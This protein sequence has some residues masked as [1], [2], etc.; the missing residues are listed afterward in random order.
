MDAR[1]SGGGAEEIFGCNEKVGVPEFLTG[2]S[3]GGLGIARTPE[4]TSPIRRPPLDTCGRA[5]RTPQPGSPA[6]CCVAGRSGHFLGKVQISH[7]LGSNGHKFHFASS[8][9]STKPK[10]RCLGKRSPPRRHPQTPA[11]DIIRTILA[12]RSQSQT[13]THY[14]MTTIDFGSSGQRLDVTLED[15]AAMALLYG[16]ERPGPHA[17]TKPTSQRANLSDFFN[18][19]GVNAFSKFKDKFRRETLLPPEEQKAKQEQKVSGSQNC[20][21]ALLDRMTQSD[22]LPIFPGNR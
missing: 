9:V 14:N 1:P 6:Q 18:V 17:P 5:G 12:K 8:G 20:R 16:F 22:R 2:T 4:R 13:H 10:R 15:V 7:F 21:C 11:V 19:Y 3:P